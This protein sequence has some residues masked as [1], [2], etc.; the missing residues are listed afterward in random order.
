MLKKFASFVVEHRNIILIVMIIITVINAVLMLQVD[1]NMDMT[2]YLPDSSDMKQGMDIMNEEF[3]DNMTSQTIRVMFTDLKD[4]EK[5]I[6]KEK[7]E[8]I[9]FVDEVT[10]DA[11]SPDYNKD[12]HTLYIINTSAEYKTPSMKKIEYALDNDFKDYNLVWK[13]DDV[14]TPEIPQGLLLLA[15]GIM[16][17]ILFVMCGS[18]I[19]PILF[20]IGIGFAVVINK[21]SNIFQGTVSYTT[22]SIAA[23]LQLVLS[24]DYS[25]ILINRYKQE[26]EKCSDIKEAMKTAICNAFPSIT[27]SGL[28]TVA[29][30]LVLVSMSFK[31]GKDV[32][33]VLAKGVALSMFAVLVIMPGI[34]IICDK[35]IKKTA[36]KEPHLPM[37]WLANFSVKFHWVIA[38]VFVLLMVGAFILQQKTEIVYTLDYE[39]KVADVF[40]PD[41]R[42]VLI[43]HN[44]DEEFATIIAG[45]LANDENVKSVMAIGTIMDSEL[46][47]PYR[48]SDSIEAKIA[49]EVVKSQ[50]V[51]EHY[52]RMIIDTTYEL[53][54]EE[55]FEFLK[56]ICIIG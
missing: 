42:L 32:G 27:S 38:G 7:L 12:N 53:E 50:L 30:L 36:K 44:N 48:D 25:I 33:I 5:A 43:Y 20:L 22:E 56:N 35:L 26:R 40:T 10:Y 13:N 37:G 3:P 52:S 45:G 6:V 51:G 55:T 29:G 1:I 16:L 31:I 4:V 41:N 21:G 46:F 9:S 54:S 2:K 24:M 14:G 28:T 18:W 8:N 23:I 15:I 11:D 47:A 49:K 39:D 17:A 19:E 34:F